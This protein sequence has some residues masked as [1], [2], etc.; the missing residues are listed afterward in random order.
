MEDEFKVFNPCANFYLFNLAIRGPRSAA[1]RD[2]ISINICIFFGGKK[3]RFKIILF[4]LIILLPLILIF[5]STMSK[6]L[7]PFFQSTWQWQKYSES[8]VSIR[9]ANWQE[10]GRE[11]L[12]N[13]LFG[14]GYGNFRDCTGG[15]WAHNLPLEILAEAGLIGFIP[16]ILIYF[17]TAHAAYLFIKRGQENILMKTLLVLWIFFIASESLI[18]GRIVCQT[19]FFLTT[20]LIW[21]LIKHYNL[22]YAGE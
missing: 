18:Y 8:S 3:K 20:G 21:G 1:G 2:F 9:L 11:F 22:K 10:A 6:N 13:P 7:G 15:C 17:L 12:S 19:S 14:I 4:G 16:L 5:W